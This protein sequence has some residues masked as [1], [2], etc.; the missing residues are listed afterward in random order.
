MEKNSI[1]MVMCAGMLVREDQVENRL[2]S[3]RRGRELKALLADDEAKEREDLKK[4]GYSPSE[5]ACLRHANRIRQME[6]Q[7]FGTI[8]RCRIGQPN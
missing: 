2:K 4:A 6:S 1:K 7:G 5:I 8:T 3:L